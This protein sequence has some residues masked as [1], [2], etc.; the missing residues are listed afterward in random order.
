MY[1]DKLIRSCAKRGEGWFPFLG[2]PAATVRVS[3]TLPRLWDASWRLESPP[4]VFWQGD[5][6]LSLT[7]H[8]AAVSLEFFTSC[9]VN[10]AG[11]NAEL[12]SSVLNPRRFGADDV[13]FLVSEP[14]ENSGPRS[15]VKP[16]P[17]FNLI[18]GQAQLDHDLFARERAVAH[19]SATR[20]HFHLNGAWQESGRLSRVTRC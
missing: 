11:R 8:V 16:V 19:D 15:R 7:R 20:A 13:P 5:A 9:A 4:C 10:V 14:L 18:Q 12:F 3:C 1:Y 2:N 6:Q 17:A